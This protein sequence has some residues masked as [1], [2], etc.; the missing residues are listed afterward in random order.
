MQKV[1]YEKYLQSSHWRQLKKLRANEVG[2]NCEACLSSKWRHGHHVNY[3]ELYDCG[4][5]DI[6]LLCS[7]CHG[8]IHSYLDV[9]ALLSS[10][11]SADLTLAIIR[12][13]LERLAR[14][15]ALQIPVDAV[16]KILGTNKPGDALALYSFYTYTSAWQGTRKILCT[17]GYVAK[18]LG[19]SRS[20]IIRAKRTLVQLG[21]IADFVRRS[22]NGQRISGWYIHIL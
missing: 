3:R 16:N 5:E 6:L 13:T 12:E 22:K 19:R 14:N 9:N 17:T 10:D 21:L 4:I 1:K 8:H 7:P 15:D 2:D 11:V 18:G 20:I